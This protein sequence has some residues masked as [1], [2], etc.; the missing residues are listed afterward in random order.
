MQE[1]KSNSPVLS[2]F[3]FA[4][5]LSLPYR[6]LWQLRVSS[7]VYI[8]TPSHLAQVACEEPKQENT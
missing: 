5:F 8:T 6:D 4:W 1:K 3:I 2:S 7:Y